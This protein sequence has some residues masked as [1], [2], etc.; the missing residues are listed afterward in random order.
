MAGGLLLLVMCKWPAQR[1]GRW[2]QI[3]RLALPAPAPATHLTHRP[4][5]P[6]PPPSCPAE[7]PYSGTN[8][9]FL[10]VLLDKK[11]AL[12]YR[13]VDA[14]V[15]CTC[16]PLAAFRPAVR[17]A[18]WWPPSVV[19]LPLCTRTTTCC[20]APPTLTLILHSALP[21]PPRWTT[22]CASRPRSASCRWC[23]SRR[24]CASCSGEPTRMRDGLVGVAT[25]RKRGAGSWLTG[26]RLGVPQPASLTLSLL[27]SSTA[28]PQVQDGGS[29]RGQGGAARPGQAAAPL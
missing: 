25:V 17:T 5:V 12:P 8:S 14:L 27:P 26:R 28:P 21:P 9:F 6:H 1:A 2:M 23:G 4:L 29:G 11:Y 16:T 7:M 15:S 19:I 18:A 22:F 24:C 13:V 20:S 10:R 3:C